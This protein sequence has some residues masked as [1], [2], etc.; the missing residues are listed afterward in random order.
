[1]SLT[2]R[3]LLH[4]CP[5]ALGNRACERVVSTFTKVQDI[6][7]NEVEVRAKFRTLGTGDV[8]FKTLDDTRKGIAIISLANPERKNALTGY[9]MV[10]LAEIIDKL[11]TWK[12]G[13]AL[14]LHGVNGTFCSGADLSVAKAIQTPEEGGQMCAFMQRTLTRLR[15]LP[16]ISVAAI[17]GKALGG[18]AEVNCNPM[19]IDLR[20]IA[21]FSCHFEFLHSLIVLNSLPLIT[22]VLLVGYNYKFIP[23]QQ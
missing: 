4:G 3:V 18:G 6:S 16:M 14:I 2:L 10:K 15:R 11:E 20:H 1:M 12:E 5:Q 17:E 22:V 8:F 7:F 23:M 21:Q 9:M 13:K 19:L